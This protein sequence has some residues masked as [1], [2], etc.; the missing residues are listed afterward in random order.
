MQL[1]PS[2]MD[3]VVREH[4]ADDALIAVHRAKCGLKLGLKQRAEPWL[5]D[6][7]F[8]GAW[9]E[10]GDGLAVHFP[11]MRCVQA[12]APDGEPEAAIKA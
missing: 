5:F 11:S 10:V 12:V 6:E 9:R 7:V 1:T 8:I 2:A 3:A 4:A